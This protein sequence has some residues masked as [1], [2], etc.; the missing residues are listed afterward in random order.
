MDPVQKYLLKYIAGTNGINSK[1]TK[2]WSL[3]ELSPSHLP[4]PC[5]QATIVTLVEAY[6]C[7]YLT[8]FKFNNFSHS[9]A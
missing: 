2:D 9:F 8:A 1:G 7:I 5:P 4:I 6:K 3:W